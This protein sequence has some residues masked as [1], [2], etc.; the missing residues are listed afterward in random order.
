M[1]KKN[2]I[3]GLILFGSILFLSCRKAK[4]TEELSTYSKGKYQELEKVAKYYK[5]DS[6]KLQATYFL[7]KNIQNKYYYTG[8]LS[9]QYDTLFHIYDSLRQNGIVVGDPPII[10]ETWKSLQQQYGKL[11][12]KRLNQQWD[13]KALKADFLINNIDWAFEAWNTSPNYENIDFDTFCEFILP[14]RAGTEIPEEY[15]ERYYKEFRLLRDTSQTDISL[16]KAFNQ[17]FYWDR[18]YKP[19]ELMWGYPLD[20]SISKM[21]L[22][23]RGTCRHMSVFCAQVM[24]AC[25]IPVAIDHVKTWGNRSRG[26]AWNVLIQ[27]SGKILPFDSFDN[28]PLEFVYKPA[29]IFRKMYSVGWLPKD[30]P[31]INDAPAELLLANEQD[32]THQY[33]KTY[34]IELVC[35]Y[36][37]IGK[38]S[39]KHGVICVFDNKEWRPVYWGHCKKGKMFFK[40][41]MG[42]VCYMAAYYENGKI[43][44]ASVPFIL[45]EEGAIK[46][47]SI[48]HSQ[49]ADMTLLRKYPRFAR[50]EMFAMNLRR[51]VIEGANNKKFN[52][53]T[54]LFDI[55]ETP[56]DV[57]ELFIKKP[58]KFRYIR[59]KIV[60]YR[61]GDLAEV[62]FYGKRTLNAPEEKLTGKIIGCPEITPEQSY[63]YINA[64]DGDPATF[65]AKPKNELGYV[66]LDLGEGNEYYITRVLFHPR[67]DTNFILLGDTYELCYWDNGSWISAGK[68]KAKTHELTFKDVPQNTFYIL[69]DLTKGK[70]ERIFTYENGKQ[71]WW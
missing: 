60:D 65:F 24:R 23:R 8:K 59:W 66:G 25:G 47:L 3:T 71:V 42:D 56:H 41:M 10:Q 68:Q 48:Q 5:K 54:L 9:N 44:P 37:Y 69:H 19:S 46:K 70:E 43:I 7:I 32:V 38:K 50:M 31:T 40:N 35:D 39:K 28:R 27:N 16:L 34:N 51:S 49:R 14:Y 18:N 13:S 22:G 58:K 30:A 36:P 11:E 67:S 52:K 2:I 64:M 26:H 61:T 29:K 57:N 6:L 21:E 12:S 15:R 62:E 63:P 33:G 53:P 45:D 17:A 55:A 4:P 20:L 1:I